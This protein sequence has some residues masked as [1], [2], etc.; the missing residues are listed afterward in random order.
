MTV[1]HLTF[2]DS[3]SFLPMALRKLHEAFG[4]SATK[5]WYPHYFNT[6]ANLDYVGSNPCI[7]QYGAAEM[8]ESE[9]KE[10]ISWYDA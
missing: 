6:I 10:F 7:E 8:S 9:R 3:I 1:E 5:C 4:L 2:L